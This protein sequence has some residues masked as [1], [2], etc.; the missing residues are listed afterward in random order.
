[1]TRRF[2]VPWSVIAVIAGVSA[3]FAAETSAVLKDPLPAPS[4]PPVARRTLSAGVAEKLAAVAPKYVPPPAPPPQAEVAP[5]S[6]EADKPRNGIVRLPSYIVQ[7]EKLPAMKER[8]MLTPQGRLDL[9]LKRHPGLRVGSFGVFKNDFWAG[10]LLEE[11]LGI[12]RQKEMYSLTSLLPGAGRPPIFT[13]RPPFATPVAASGP[14]AG[15]V[16]PWERR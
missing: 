15:L 13:G 16:V 12:E 3:A 2:Q 6:R 5:D 8:D 4:A 9:A 11:E 7:E 10:A 1:M 14:W